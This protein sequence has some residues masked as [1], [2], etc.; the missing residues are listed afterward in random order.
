MRWRTFIE[1]DKNYP[2][3]FKFEKQRL[4]AEIGDIFLEHFGSTAVPRLGGKGYVDIYVAVPKLEMRKCSLKI[5]KL[6]YEHRPDGDV[7]GERLF[8]KRKITTNSGKVITYNLHVTYLESENLQV[9]LAFRDYLR[10][11]PLDRQRYAEA[12]KEAVKHAG[13]KDKRKKAVQTY[14]ESKSAII[15]EIIRKAISDKAS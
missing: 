4:Q 12:K 10:K 13:M 11:S 8:H 1:Y 3:L 14:M 5:Q 6:G 15:K 9:C 2:K 7:P